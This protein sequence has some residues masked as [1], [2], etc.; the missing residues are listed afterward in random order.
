MFDSETNVASQCMCTGLTHALR[1]EYQEAR[2]CY[3]AAIKTAE[4]TDN[5]WLMCLS[6]LYLGDLYRTMKEYDKAMRLYEEV[7]VVANKINDLQLKGYA[8]TYLGHLYVERDQIMDTQEH[9]E[10][11]RAVQRKLYGGPPAHTSPSYAL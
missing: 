11:A 10:H 2:I 8:H 7:L 6:K 1:G 3:E 9:L 5:I 4:Q